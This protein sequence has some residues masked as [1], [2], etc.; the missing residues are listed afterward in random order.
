[1]IPVTGSASWRIALTTPSSAIAQT[2]SGGRDS[3][4]A[5]AMEA[6]DFLRLAVDSDDLPLRHVTFVRGVTGSRNAAE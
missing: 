1:M 5:K 6:I 4:A 3:K 2:S